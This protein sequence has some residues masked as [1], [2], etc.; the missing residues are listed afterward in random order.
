MAFRWMMNNPIFM[1]GVIL[2]GLFITSQV[3]EGGLGYKESLMPTSC[4][5]VLVML[6][7]RIPET[8]TTRCRGN[9]LNITIKKSMDP[10]YEEGMDEEQKLQM[11]RQLLYRELAN[12]LITIAKNSPTDN[13]ERTDYISLRL[14]HSKLE[15]G[16][17][18]EGRFVVKFSTITNTNLILEHLK[19]TVS[20]QETLK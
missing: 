15:I 14:V 10:A 1:I 20:V 9:N 18:T 16:A 4:K 3:R 12:D 8:W 2:M 17:L 5:A 7:R 6:D 13:L 11:L 19:E